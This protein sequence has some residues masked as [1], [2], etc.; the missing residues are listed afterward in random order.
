MEG[1]VWFVMK[2]GIATTCGYSNEHKC[3]VALSLIRESPSSPQPP[4]QILGT[5][6]RI[7]LENLQ[8]FV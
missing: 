1:G 4:H 7:P 2:G 6:V 5:Q 3:H 8:G